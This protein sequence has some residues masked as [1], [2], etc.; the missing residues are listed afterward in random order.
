MIHD[1]AGCK[2]IGCPQC[3][4]YR[5]G[6]R[7]GKAMQALEKNDLAPPS[8]YAASAPVRRLL[9]YCRGIT[10]GYEDTA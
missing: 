6:W 9:N 7:H 5:L 1:Y 4:D 10:D 3:A 2:Q 8:P